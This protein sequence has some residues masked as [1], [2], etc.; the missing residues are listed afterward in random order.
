MVGWLLKCSKRQH[1]QMVSRALQKRCLKRRGHPVST[2]TAAESGAQQRSP[3]VETATRVVIYV[4][5]ES[6]PL[7]MMVAAAR[8]RLAEIETSYTKDRCGV[9]ATQ[10][11]LFN[12]T[13]S[14][15]TQMFSIRYR[16]SSGGTSIG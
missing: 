12:L 9:E 4:H 6:E 13:K 2:E 1:G 15:S 8:L 5:P 11:K 10:A 3:Y 16:V 7:R 14:H